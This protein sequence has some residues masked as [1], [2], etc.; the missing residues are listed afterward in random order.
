MGM[1]GWESAMNLACVLEATSRE[2]P[3]RIALKCGDSELTYAALDTQVNRLANALTRRGIR[4]GDRIALTCVSTPAFVISYYAILKT[5]AVAVPLNLLLKQDEIAEQLKASE[6]RMYLCFEGAPEAPMGAQG[7]AAF[8]RAPSCE[9]FVAIPAQP[10]GL[11]L[12]KGHVDW[13]DLLAQETGE[14]NTVETQSGDPC[15]ITFTSGTTGAPKGA[16]HSHANEYI[17]AMAVRQEMNVRHDDVLYCALPLF[18]LWRVA[19]MHCTFLSG[20]CGVIA[21]RFDPASAWKTIAAERVTV[22]LGVAPMFYGMQQAMNELGVDCKAIAG[23]WRLCMFGGMPWDHNSRAF[24]QDAFR[25]DIRQGYGLTEVIFAVLDTAPEGNVPGRV[26]RPIAGVQVRIVDEA[27][28][29]VPQGELGEIVVRSPMTMTEYFKRPDWTESAS[30]GGWFRTGDVGHRDAD[31]NIFLVDRIKDMINRGSYKVY[32]AQVELALSEHEAVARVAVIG[33][34]DERS[35]EEVMACVVLKDGAKCSEEALISWAR[36]RMA[37]HA[38]PRKVIFMESLPVNPTG[39][40]LKR[41]L[42][43]QILAAGA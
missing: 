40:V 43:E 14:F 10:G 29:D 4:P 36:Q 5:G 42:R 12:L 25:L 15:S 13:N 11:S 26:G 22:F 6:A 34:P 20:A 32:P 8:E 2:H 19:I 41:A 35:G 23:H 3:D 9:T 16:V 38:Y 24:F 37:A 30:H 39:K 33:V 28:N 1:L 7:L 21:P 17:A 31:G 18:S 27:F